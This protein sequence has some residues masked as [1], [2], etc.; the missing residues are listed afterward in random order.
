MIRTLVRKRSVADLGDRGSFGI[1]LFSNIIKI[2][3]VTNQIGRYAI[4]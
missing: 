4:P 1:A 2:K 3:I